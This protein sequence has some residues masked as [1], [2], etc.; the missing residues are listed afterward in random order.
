MGKVKEYVK[1]QIPEKYRPYLSGPLLVIVHFKIPLSKLLS[2]KRV[3]EL[4]TQPH[5]T[6]PD[7]DNLEKFLNDALNGIVWKDDSQIAWMLRS[8]SYTYK[9]TGSTTIFVRQLTY[10]K[11]EYDLIL[12]DIKEHLKL[13]DE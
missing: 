11:P 13:E 1:K 5:T 12:A 3:E 2:K 9:K 8:K 6:R 7:G 10:G 4:D